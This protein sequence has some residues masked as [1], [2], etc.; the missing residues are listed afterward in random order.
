M[1]RHPRVR[2]IAFGLL[3]AFVSPVAAEAPTAPESTAD[4]R[5]KDKKKGKGKEKRAGDPN[6]KERID[7]Q[8]ARLEQRAK[9][10]RDDGKA[11]EADRLEQRAKRLRQSADKGARRGKPASPEAERTR[12]KYARLKAL[13]KQYGK[14]LDQA[15]VQRELSLHAERSAR[16]SRMK[17][18]A[19]EHGKADLLERILKMMEREDARHEQAMSKLRAQDVPAT[20]PEETQ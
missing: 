20:T 14:D 12:R 7:K 19:E 8:A 15:P 13:R 6:R 11:D 3:T 2:A 16:L 10:L 5:P 17:Q 4:R 9:R 1:L 18:L